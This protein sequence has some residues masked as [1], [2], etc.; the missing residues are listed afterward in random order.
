MFHQFSKVLESKVGLFSSSMGNRMVYDRDQGPIVSIELDR[1]CWRESKLCEERVKPHCLPSGL[2]ERDIFGISCSER[3]R[4][5]P[6]GLPADSPT[7]KPESITTGNST[8]RWVARCKVAIAESVELG[9]AFR[10]L[11]PRRASRGNWSSCR[12]AHGTLVLYERDAALRDRTQHVLPHPNALRAWEAAEWRPWVSSSSRISSIFGDAVYF[13][14]IRTSSSVLAGQLE[15]HSADGYPITLAGGQSSSFILR[16][17][18][19]LG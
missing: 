12:A 2:R 17:S 16:F 18:S 19:L 3:D 4:P 10:V 1:A 11:D 6:F 5:L 9:Q 7:P 15:V 8:S 13:R 14:D